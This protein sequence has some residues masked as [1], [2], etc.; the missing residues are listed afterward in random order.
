MADETNDR[1][2]ITQTHDRRPA[3]GAASVEFGRT[4][5]DLA[6][7]SLA[8]FGPDP[9]AGDASE[10]FSS[11]DLDN[12]GQGPIRERK[13][14]PAIPPDER[15]GLRPTIKGDAAPDTPVNPDFYGA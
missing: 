3:P 11:D 1:S 14:N 10:Q 12:E 5:E 7:N 9:L 8:T 13:R 4:S 15:L 6:T 2:S